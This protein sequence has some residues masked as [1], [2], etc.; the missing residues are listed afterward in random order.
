MANSVH[1]TF[2]IPDLT[3]HLLMEASGE[4]FSALLDYRHVNKFWNA[5]SEILLGDLWGLAYRLIS[6]ERWMD[7]FTMDRIENP[8]LPDEHATGS[9]F[10]RL[11][12][13]EGGA[14][15]M[16]CP[17]IKFKR[18]TNVFR[19]HGAEVSIEFTAVSIP[20]FQMLRNKTC[21][22]RALKVVWHSQL[23]DLI[24]EEADAIPPIDADAQKIRDFLY[25]RK[26]GLLLEQITGPLNLTHLDGVPDDV[27][28][29]IWRPMIQHAPIPPLNA[30]AEDIRSFLNDPVNDLMLGEIAELDLEGLNLM[31]FPPELERLTGLTILKLTHNQ[32]REVQN[33]SFQHL[34]ELYLNENMLREV[35]PFALPCLHTFDLCN[36]QL[37]DFPPFDLPLVES[38]D[39][40]HNELNELPDLANYEN[41]DAC[42]FAGNAP[43]LIPDGVL[44]RFP[45]DKAIM[46][47]VS[48]LRYPCE[49]PMAKLY[50]AI[51]GNKLPLDQIKTMFNALGKEDRYRIFEMA[52]EKAGKPDAD[53]LQWGDTHA[54]D[55]R[56]NFGLAVQKTI[57]TKFE[58]LSEEQRIQVCSEIYNLTGQ[59]R[60][61]D[62]EWMGVEH[63]AKKYILPLTD[64]LFR[65]IKN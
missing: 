16:N 37:S 51:M 23:R 45:E 38:L 28:M 40:S 32:L 22:D 60:A 7:Y 44:Q 36:N 25:T 20:Q 30:N 4:R 15:D 1:V 26:Y 65:C 6:Q 35:P 3:R 17:V 12:G 41:L 53:Y 49:S 19:N 39:I 50:Q 55:D 29:D 42:S 24:Q 18:L 61:K 46:S 9:E 59:P 27:L 2:C 56:L 33:F 8:N 14:I 47:F 52:W 34:E 10:K 58:R 11:R 63:T 62:P 21:H 57:M 54:F 43:M 31:V 64:A 5:Q 48:Q 13:I